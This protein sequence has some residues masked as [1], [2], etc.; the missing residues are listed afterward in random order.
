[1]R[2]FWFVVNGHVVEVPIFIG[3]DCGSGLFVDVGVMG[4]AL[5]LSGVDLTSGCACGCMMAT[6]TGNNCDLAQLG[7]GADFGF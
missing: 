3:V 5:A 7:S 1:M 4:T 6:S 2:Y